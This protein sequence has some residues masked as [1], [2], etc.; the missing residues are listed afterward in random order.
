MET[1]YDVK[2]WKTKAYVGRTKT[3]Y[4]VRWKVATKRFNKPFHTGA[5]AESFRSELLSAARKGEAFRV[6]DGF[7]VSRARAANTA[8]WFDF[9]CAYVD[10]K[11]RDV[12]PGHRRNI[13]DALA[14]VTPKML[15]NERGQPDSDTLRVA[16]LRSFNRHL[17]DEQS[18][19]EVM[20]TIRWLQQNT[21]PVAALAEPETLHGVLEALGSKQDGSKCSPDTLRRKR[22]T[23]TNILDYAVTRKLL[24]SNP[25]PHVQAANASRTKAIRQVDRRAVVNPVQA[26]SLLNGVRDV[27]MRGHRL[28]AFFGCMY[29]AALRPEEAVWLNKSN[30]SLPAKGWGELHLTGA[31]PEVGAQWTDTRS[32]SEERGLKHRAPGEGRTVPCPP[33][34]TALLHEHVEAFSVTEDGRLFRGERSGNRVTSS[35]YT[36]VWTLARR[37]VF[38][39]AVAASPLAARPYDLRHACVSTWLAG[40]VAPTRVAEWAG[41]SV[42]VLLQIYAKVLDGGDQAALAQIDAVLG[43]PKR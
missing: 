17:R 33:E 24:T 37:A 32:R 16:A 20:R 23:L 7:P 28:L 25:L 41:H 42:A 29:F 1:T 5:L 12:S 14:T 6:E 40:G 19:Q 27:G 36:N 31:V 18:S 2:V 39:P 30:L 10:F 8:A 11:W 13:A 26:R 34:L 35:T 15:K 3:T 38:T 4:Y 43:G 9:A 22:M 21:R